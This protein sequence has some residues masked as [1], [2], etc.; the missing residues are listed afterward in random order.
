MSSSGKSDKSSGKAL[1][2]PERTPAQKAAAVLALLDEDTLQRLA[3]RLPDRHRDRLLNAVRSLRKVDVHEQRRIAQEFAKEMARGRN[4][5]RGNDDVAERLK[6]ALFQEPLEELPFEMGD[7]MGDFDD[8]AEEEETSVWDRVAELPPP[9]LVGFFNGKSSSVLSIAMSQ[10][11]DDLVTELTGELDE[12]AVKAAMVHFATNGKPNPVAIDAVA[13]LLEEELLNS[14]EPMAEVSVGGVNSNLDKVAGYLNRMISSRR[15]ATME[16][17][18]QELSAED[19][20]ILEAKVLSFPAL[21]D[22]LPRSA[23][24]MVLRELDE[25]TLLVVLKYGTKTASSAVDY[26]LNNISQRLAGQYREKMDEMPDID[27][28]KGEK[29]TSQFI[30]KILAMADEGKFSL[31]TD[32]D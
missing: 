31:A 22:R 21:E 3:G 2:S 17:L 18:R 10:L 32:D 1:P 11:P 13:R 6:A 16:A 12:A 15:D 28:E 25:K 29:A 8:P 19:M 24:P 30:C 9:V 20:A 4:A 26:L 27:E 5:V 7:A 23:I 14:D